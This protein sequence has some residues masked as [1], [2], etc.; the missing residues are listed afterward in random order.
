MI[1]IAI[2]A[3]MLAPYDLEQIFLRDRLAPPGTPGFPLGTDSLGKDVLTRLLYSIQLSMVVATLGT[4]IGGILGTTLGLIAAYFGGIVDETIMLFVDFQASLPAIIFA[5]TLLAF[6]GNSL[7]LFILVLG[8][9][10]WEGYAR[11]A[12]GLALSVKEREYV[13]AAETLGASAWRIYGLHVFPNIANAI[14]VNFTLNFPGTI[15]A[16]ATLSFLGLGVQPPNTSLGLMLSVGRN[17]LAI[18]WWLAV[19]PGMVIFFTTLSITI[20]GDWLRDILDP[21]SR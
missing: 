6:F 2:F 4:L 14:I 11:I 21:T 18:Q 15:L 8:V 12:R 19:F 10:G 16:E 9:L 17:Y 13:T 1:F 20:L 3:D 7:T 5:L